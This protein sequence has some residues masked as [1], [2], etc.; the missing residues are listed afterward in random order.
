MKLTVKSVKAV[1]LP[2]GKAEAIFFDDDVPGF[3]LR[4]REGGSRSLIFQYKI[5]EKHRRMALG[6]ANA[7]DFAATRKEAEKLYARVKL[8][9]DPAGDKAEAKAK[10]AE[11]FEA[12]AAD[13]LE[14]KKD[15]LRERSYL[16]VVRYLKVHAK[17]LHRLQLAKVTRADIAACLS[18]ARKGSGAV[19]ANRT[20][21]SLSAFYAWCMGQGLVEAN[22]VVGTNRNEEKARE[23]VLPPPELRLI[24][25]A[26]EAD[27][28]GDIVRLLMLT[29]QRLN[30]IGRLERSEIDLQK[31]VISLASDRTKNERPHTVPLSAP[32]RAILEGRPLRIDDDGEPRKFV[33]GMR[34][35]P[36]TNWSASKEQLDERITAANGGKP[37]E[38]WTHHD[39]R[40]S[41]ATHAAELGI[42]APHIVE[43]ILN[44]VSGH[45][46]GVAGVYNKAT[47]EP[48]KRT[49]LVRWAEQLLA[50]VEGRESNVTPLRRA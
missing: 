47:Y 5:G 14:L 28:Y 23:R 46:A 9:D 42:I 3:G 50:W 17:V 37:L 24:W 13:Y 27:D 45:K 39:L 16:D 29:G 41:F 12:A 43:T 48:E 34:K 10:A 30:E 18:S 25:N 21:S 32:A 36:F 1:Q 31:D 26:L 11:T 19:T 33:F 49:G 38:R 22:P 35:G 6:S 15:E 20:R 4:V 40:R 8:G 44:H 7:V 2:K